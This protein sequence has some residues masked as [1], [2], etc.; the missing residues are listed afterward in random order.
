MDKSKYIGTHKFW[1]SIGYGND[2]VE[3]VM[4]ITKEDL[5]EATTESE[6]T[7]RVEELFQE[8]YTISS[9]G[10]IVL[11]LQNKKDKN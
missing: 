11:P 4:K 10:D 8:R 1:V 2:K 7:A 9:N 5:S 3:D 6:L